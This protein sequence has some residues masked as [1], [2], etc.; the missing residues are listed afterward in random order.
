MEETAP[1]L[2]NDSIDPSNNEETATETEDE[3][4]VEDVVTTE[5]SLAHSQEHPIEPTRLQS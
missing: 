2:A 3:D 4:K 1:Y 5:M